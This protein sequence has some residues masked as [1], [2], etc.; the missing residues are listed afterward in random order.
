MYHSCRSQAARF[1]AGSNF[2]VVLV[3][4]IQYMRAVAAIMVLLTHVASKCHAFGGSIL[5]EFVIGNMGVDIFF[6]ISG[7]IMC[8]VGQ[9]HGVRIFLRHRVKRI[10]PLYWLLTTVA[11]GVFLVAPDKVN[12]SSTGVTSI[13]GSY[14]L[15]PVWGNFLVQNGWTLS[16]EFI[17]YLIFS[18][19][20][21]CSGRA[22]LLLPMAIIVALV[23]AGLCGLNVMVL[24]NPMMLEFLFGMIVFVWGHRILPGLAG[25]WLLLLAAIYLLV[26]ASIGVDIGR[27]PALGLA[28]AMIFLGMLRLEA[29]FVARKNALPSRLM[30]SLGD[31]SY[32][33]YLCHPFALSALTMIMVRTGI[34]S[35]SLQA[36]ILMLMTALVAGHVCH[37]YIERVLDK[38]VTRN[39]Q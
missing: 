27:V 34:V 28:A 38:L 21:L 25:H 14:T 24:T 13:L 22:K 23:V 4:S 9:K 31:S 7:Y 37:R 26:L 12:S 32:S 3:Y 1:S 5:G 20:L 17:F 19:G 35:S 8:M 36:I 39:R 33:L 15:I 11:L 10:I 6:V 2:E 29:F 30:K 16:Y 18:A